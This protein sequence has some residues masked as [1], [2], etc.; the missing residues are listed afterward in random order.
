VGEIRRAIS[1]YAQ[2]AWPVR[3]AS[4]PLRP[5]VEAGVAMAQSYGAPPVELTIPEGLPDIFVGIG[6]VELCVANVLVHCRYR[7]AENHESVR[8]TANEATR[9]VDGT[10]VDHVR[11][12]FQDSGRPLQVWQWLEMFAVNRFGPEGSRPLIPLHLAS[13]L[14]WFEATGVPHNTLDLYWRT[15]DKSSV[16]LEKLGL[17]EKDDPEPHGP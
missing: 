6:Q 3:T 4:Y 10:L 15:E 9:D 2:D 13:S 5:L 17:E 16:I 8:I 12:R 11:L 14:P 7:L 1:I